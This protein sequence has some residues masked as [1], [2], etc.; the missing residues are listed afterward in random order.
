MKIVDLKYAV[1]EGFPTIR[2]DTNEGISGIS[3]LEYFK[4]YLEPV[5]MFLKDRIL[6]EDPTNVERVMRRIR[7]LGSFK[8]W[9]SAV[10]AIEIALWDIAGKAAGLPVYKLLGGKVRDKVR[11]YCTGQGPWLKGC[12]PENY[13]ELAQARL[14]LP[15][16]FTIMKFT[17][18]MDILG[19]VP[20]SLYGETPEIVAGPHTFRPVRGH[21]T[22]RGLKYLISC[23]EAIKDVTRDKVGIAFDCGPRMTLPSAIKLARALE[24]YEVMWLED[25]LTGD[26]TPYVD[27]E[28]Y[29]LLSSS[30]TTPIHTGEQIY[31][32]QGFKE[33]IE[34]HAVDSIGPDPCDV[35]GIAE[36]KWIAELAAL[37][38]ILIIPHGLG[39]GPVGVAAHV[40]VAAT[41]PE[42]FVAFELPLLHPHKLLYTEQEFKY[43]SSSE[44]LVK[45]LPEPLVKDGYIEVLDKPGLGVE[46]NREAVKKYL[47]EGNTFFE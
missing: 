40:Q 45:G 3:Q 36:L 44:K 19:Y 34:K 43:K 42:N 1:L 47:G 15:E 10:S 8:P 27:V 26:Y 30:T 9:G 32:R 33:L 25:M 6:G 24:P 4:P 20:G 7:R 2:I 31:L 23:V 46:L 17:L 22:E 12:K 38:D 14:K 28:A 21:L 16:G 41:L 35:G 13:A 11:V 18:G 39:D 29:R 37:H 5:L